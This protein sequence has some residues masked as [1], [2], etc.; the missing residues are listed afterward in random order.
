LYWLGADRLLIGGY[1]DVRAGGMVALLDPS[2]MEGQAPEA[3]DAP[4]RCTNCGGAAP[5]R[6]I[7]MPP[8][9][10]NKV[11][12]SRFNRA[13]VQL[14]PDRIVA[15]TI[16]MEQTDTH[17]AI[18][19]LYDFSKSLDLLHAS[20]GG[21]YWE[22]HAELERQGKLN[23]SRAQCPDRDGPREVLVWTP[24]TGWRRTA[25]PRASS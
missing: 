4:A 6:M 18:D 24:D 14:M 19:V 20:F 7:V 16:E 17:P 13:S 21:N 5:L 1:D 3:I 2:N 25:I 23:H 12:V 15:R 11:T 10:I 9:E 22:M 8:T